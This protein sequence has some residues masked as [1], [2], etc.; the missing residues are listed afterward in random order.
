MSNIVLK[1]DVLQNIG[2]FL[3]N[4]YI[5]SIE[6]T[7]A[8]TTSRRTTFAL[9]IYFSVLFLISDEYDVSDIK[10]QIEDVNFY[11]SFKNAFYTKSGLLGTGSK[12]VDLLSGAELSSLLDNKA[13]YQD[14]LYDEEG[15]RVLKVSTN[16]II[17][18]ELALELELYLYTFSSLL[19]KAQYEYTLSGADVPVLYLNT[20]NVSYEKIFSS[21]YKILKEEQ[22][23]Y[24]DTA[25]Q[26][27]GQVPLL[28]L[29]RNY[30]KTSTVTREEIVSSV[31]ALLRRFSVRNTSVLSDSVNSIKYVLRT[32]SDTE[33]LLVE[34]D[35]VRKSFPNKTNNNPVGNLYAAYSKLLQN[36]N[37]SFP[38]VDIVTKDRYMTG[39]V[40]DKRNPRG[41]ELTPIATR[42]SV[43]A[44]PADLVFVHRE[45]PV[46]QFGGSRGAFNEGMFFVRFEEILKNE[47]NI[48]VLLDIERLY[49]VFT[50]RS[51]NSLRRILFSYLPMSRI[52]I[53]KSH[54]YDGYS[55]E[56]TQHLD[57]SFPE[58]KPSYSLDS[59]DSTVQSLAL[60]DIEQ[61][62]EEYNFGFTAPL[63]KLLCFRFLD[64]DNFDD[65]Y[66]AIQIEN[67]GSVVFTYTFEAQMADRTHDF[68]IFL[69]DK[70]RE[71][72]D[73]FISYVDMANE[74]CSYNNIENRFNDFFVNSI[75]EQYPDDMYPWEIAPTFYSMMAYLLSDTTFETLPEAMEYSKNISAV[76]SPENG[77]LSSL[78]QFRA[79]LDEFMITMDSFLSRANTFSAVQVFRELQK[80]VYLTP[81][82]YRG[83]A[84][85]D[86]LPDEAE[87]DS[88][89]VI[90]G[91]LGG[92]GRRIGQRLT[93]MDTNVESTAEAQQIGDGRRSPPTGGSEGIPSEV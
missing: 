66:D 40:V 2:E 28:G 56:Q 37:S 41:T 42:S 61:G 1:G 67:V 68:A 7:T 55:T 34:L 93:T 17:N 77:N 27:Y 62:I 57:F 30:Y 59:G 71:I 45:R 20:S 13:N 11:C 24:H 72:Y 16:R 50:N 4:V 78:E 79:V 15:R 83:S 48:S 51:L 6:V 80:E 53:T 88:G 8:S 47:T 92:G 74:I 46:D 70:Y 60:F 87:D 43:D 29:D 18:R 52:S 91:G 69:Y 76:V 36:F 44:I 33:N 32:E 14:D 86:T 73:N 63:E 75:K 39:K 90:A 89:G 81:L 25:G 54:D 82:S 5:E 3:P 58:R 31:N 38:R 84:A 12:P 26:K 64:I 9:D 23:I 10:R 85:L 22:V 49:Q 65:A 35:K 21:G 19:D